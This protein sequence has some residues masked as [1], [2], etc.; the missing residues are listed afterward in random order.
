M[1]KIWGIK[2]RLRQISSASLIICLVTAV[3]AGCQETPEVEIVK[4]KKSAGEAETVPEDSNLTI[5]E[6]VQAPDTYTASFKDSTGQIQVRADA[7]VVVPDAEGFRLKKVETRDFTQEDLDKVREVLTGNAQ[8]WNKVY[9]EN[10]PA[11]GYTKSEIEEMIVEL[12][13][14][15]A[16][17]G[18]YKSFG[19]EDMPYEES[20]DEL[21]AMYEAAPETCETELLDGKLATAAEAGGGGAQAGGIS[22]TAT[23]DG[24]DYGIFL[25]NH[26]TEDW[27]W[28]QLQVIRMDLS[29]NYMPVYGESLIDELKMGLKIS[30]EDIE[31]Q[32]DEIVAKLGFTEMQRAGG[33]Y[34]TVGVEIQPG[35]AAPVGEVGYG[36]HYTRVTE[37]IPVTY[38]SADGGTSEHDEGQA[39]Y[40]PAWPYEGLYLIYDDGGLASFY[41]GDPYKLEDISEEYVFLLPFSEI[42]KIFE[43]MMTAKYAFLPEG[44]SHTEFEIKEVRLG[45]MRIKEKNNS[46][47]GTLVPVWDFFGSRVMIRQTEAGEIR[48]VADG[49]YNSWFTINAMDGTV[50]DR[51]FGY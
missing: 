50:I 10:D 31:K 45:Y 49:P 37:G 14:A 4:Q 42:E 24:K 47:V 19:T 33:E 25:D 34:F 41:W 6:Q 20:L 48:D 23:V 29:S 35:E 11:R 28:I 21:R 26:R 36:V 16:G 15:E 13:K 27:K 30:V 38:T 22:A 2:Q 32:S 9:K 43:E 18:A 8:L 39:D 5:A 51:D 44:D 7:R 17:G 40:S 12:E 3:F 46:D 1:K